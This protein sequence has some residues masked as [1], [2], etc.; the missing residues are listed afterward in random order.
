MASLPRFFCPIAL[1][2][3]QSLDLPPTAA[4]HVQVLR[5]QPGQSVLLFGS[6]QGQWRA[7]IEEIGRS[8]VRV[9]PQ[10][11]ADIARE[12]PLRVHL[13]MALVANDRM[14]HLLEKATEL[15]AASF[16]PLETER[17]VV[18]LS[19]DRAEKRRQHWQ[20]VVAS[21]CEQCG[22]NTVPQVLPTQSLTHYLS[23]FPL[24]HNNRSARY[25]LSLSEQAQPLMRV[26]GATQFQPSSSIDLVSGPEGGWSMTE[27]S[28]LVQAG[29][30]Q[31]SLGPRTL[32]A[33]T[34]PLAALSALTLGAHTG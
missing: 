17:C 32:R 9:C 26:A 8:H 7:C 24:L 34:A 12:T 31:V 2:T 30:I 33:D 10:E 21:A 20:A 27:E 22:R 11:F 19:G 16:S 6:G 15:G 28:H 18:K 4:R 13:V 23:S 3:G 5:M 1:Q 29:L 14:D 25:L